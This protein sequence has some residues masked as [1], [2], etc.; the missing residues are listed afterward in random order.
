MIRQVT[1][2]HISGGNYFCHVDNVEMESFGV[3]FTDAYGNVLGSRSAN[4]LLF[5]II[6][7]IVYTLVI[8]FRDVK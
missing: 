8:N 6:S 2:A 4:K 7:N 1:S 3:Y 5:K